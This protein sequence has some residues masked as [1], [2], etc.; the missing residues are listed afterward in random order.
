MSE[1]LEPPDDWVDDFEDQK[2]APKLAVVREL[3]IEAPRDPNAEDLG[4]TWHFL[5]L[6]VSGKKN[7]VKKCPSNLLAIL[8]RDPRWVGK[9]A[10]CKLLSAVVWTGEPV[11]L[12]AHV[13]PREPGQ[14][15]VTEQDI[16]Q[17]QAWLDRIFEVTWECGA[18][19]SALETLALKHQVHPFL[20]LVSQTTWDG[21]ARIDTFFTE[22]LGC[23]DEPGYLAICARVLF[24]G[25]MSR[26][27][28]PGEKLDD[29]VILEGATGARKSGMLSA[30]AGRREWFSDT[31][32]NLQSGG[33]KDAMG[34]LRGILIY[35]WAELDGFI[36]THSGAVKAFLS[37]SSDRYRAPYAKAE[38]QYPRVSIITG[39]T[40]ESGGYL[41][42][43]TGLRRYWPTT[44]AQEIDVARIEADHGQ[45]WSEALHRVRAG[46]KTYSTREEAAHWAHKKERRANVDPWVEQIQRWLG[47]P[48]NRPHGMGDVVGPPVDVSNGV[49]VCDVLWHAVGVKVENQNKD[50]GS[51][52][53]R[54]LRA[55]GWV[56]CPY[57]DRRAGLGAPMP[58]AHIY[59]PL[60]DWLE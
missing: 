21:K 45:L 50:N 41:D 16:V 12:R 10:W 49:T 47:A 36:G 22:Y 54:H 19:Y 7:K 15:E 27:L 31:R 56:P 40:N 20:D 33:G 4:N 26:V 46:E 1:H 59:K 30:I 35:E 60:A 55:L 29:M 48:S 23:E 53:A 52:C 43:P 51:R 9:F 44:T 38:R 3:R 13:A 6:T 24:L 28:K 34:A 58:R 32:I 57:G 39:T 11:A 17:I 2:P 37:S 5:E 18:I 25:L 8:D 42:D 14:R